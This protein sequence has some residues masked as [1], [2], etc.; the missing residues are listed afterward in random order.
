MNPTTM[1]QIYTGVSAVGS[2]VSGIAQYKQGVEEQRAYKYNAALAL[3]EAEKE[4]A[5]SRSKFQRLKGEQIT[6]Y[7]KSGVD[8]FSGSP[9]LILQNTLAQAEQE[10]ANI[11][12]AGRSKAGMD[13][14]YGRIAKR[15]GTIG[16]ISTFLSGLG[17]AGLNY[18]KYSTPGVSTPKSKISDS[19]GT[20]Y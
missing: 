11:D 9:L 19:W 1:A 20:Y 16:G 18:A 15:R 4:K 12:E 5:L 17:N 7:G 6:G 13:L 10:Q 14:Y 8:P 2:G 3:R